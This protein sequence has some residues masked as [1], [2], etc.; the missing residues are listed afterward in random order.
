MYKIAANIVKGMVGRLSNNP[1]VKNRGEIGWLQSKIIKHQEDKNVKSHQ[2]KNF[3]IFYKRPYELLHT[4]EDL[5]VHEIYKF[6]SPVA[7]PFIIDCGANI[8]MSV[9]YFKSLFPKAHISVFEPDE[10][11]FALLSKNCKANNLQHVQL[12]KAAVWINNGKI[13]FDAR[14]SEGSHITEEG[15]AGA[16]EVTAVRLADELE[17]AA[18]V[19]FLK[20]DIEG[21]EHTVLQ[22]CAAMLHKVENMFLE[23]HGTAEETYKLTDIFSILQAAGFSVYI[24]VAADHLQHPFYQKKAASIYDVQLNLF[25]YRK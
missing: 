18:T 12:N 1:N 14:E 11:N 13:S 3:T 2:F 8:G 19:H 22:D 25:C 21:A 10:K 9:L 6:R 17:K 16:N 24:K 5:F 23:Y 20:I 15:V 7:D 4:Y